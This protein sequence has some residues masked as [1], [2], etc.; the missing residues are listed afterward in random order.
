[1]S[2]NTDHPA[3][4]AEFTGK[5]EAETG[6]I[7][8]TLVG[9]F[10]TT[11]GKLIP[12]EV[13]TILEAGCGAGYSAERILPLLP[14]GATYEGSD[15]GEDLITIA[16]E[17][18]PAVS[19]TVES[20]YDL[21]RPDNSYDCTLALE[22]LEHLEDPLAALR[23]LKR[24]SRKYVILSVPREPLWRVLN[25]A[26]GTYLS[27]FGNT[28]GHINHWSS[29][30]FARFVSQELSVV[31]VRKPLPWTMLLARVD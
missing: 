4:V 13:T 24:V 16:R 10:Y 1:M 23:E 31:E 26:R 18:V 14:A 8:R 15:I 29:H 28:P 3:H 5:Y 21:Q 9:N 20:I 25:M 19:F 2:A 30:G 17:K 22:T 6:R 27:N 12:P 7:A 11:L